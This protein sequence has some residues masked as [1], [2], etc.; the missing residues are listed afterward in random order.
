V[1]DGVWAG[2]RFV[3]FLAN[4]PHLRGR[5]EVLGP[6]PAP[7]QD[8]QIDAAIE[9]WRQLMVEQLERMRQAEAARAKKRDSD[10]AEPLD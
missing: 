10:L 3:D 9:G 5:T 6:F 8:E 2:R 4:V 7:E 1:T